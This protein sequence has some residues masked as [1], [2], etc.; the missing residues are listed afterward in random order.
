MLSFEKPFRKALYI[1]AYT[2]SMHFVK[3]HIGM[4]INV[5]ILNAD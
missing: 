5:I 4:F 3:N 2:K 1:S